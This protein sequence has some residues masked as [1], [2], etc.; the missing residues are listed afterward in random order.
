M[1]K[2]DWS[3]EDYSRS[4][5]K[6]ELRDARGMF[7][8]SLLVLPPLYLGFWFMD[9]LWIPDRKW[10][11]L[12]I[13]CVM[14]CIAFILSQISARSTK[15]K[16]HYWLG[17]IYS[18]FAGN[19]I[20]LMIAI[21]DG[22]TSPYYAGLNLV[23]LGAIWFIPANVKYLAIAIAAICLP[24]TLLPLFV[25]TDSY[26]QFALNN[27]FI[28]GTVI[29]ALF[30]RYTHKRTRESEI[31]ARLTLKQEV[32]NR[33][34]I[35]RE[36]TEEALKLERLS[37]QFS[38]QIVDAIK[39]GEIKLDGEMKRARIAAIFIDIVGSTDR[40][41]NLDRDVF[42]VVLKR[43]MEEVYGV[44]LKYDLTIDKFLGDGVLAFSNEPVKRS[45]FIERTCFA[46]AEIKSRLANSSE[47]FEK[48][49]E[50]KFEIRAG[51]S[52]GHA[53]V[54][55]HGSEKYY[56]SYTAIGRPMA[57]AARLCALAEPGTIVIDA[58]IN[59]VISAEGFQ[60][61]F[62]AKKTLRGF[63]GEVANTYLLDL[64]PAQDFIDTGE[65]ACVACGSNQL[66]LEEANGIYFM[67]CRNCGSALKTAA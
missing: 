62:L 66:T 45:D 35:I 12:G 38:P 10:E 22:P 9:I 58:D 37:S 33:E 59:Q 21:G 13:R 18:F 32:R 63:E 24:Y 60:T 36:K 53:N 51:I 48:Y 19:F 56:K 64:A 67:K 2:R 14:V 54:G 5:A 50:K 20:T 39:S 23:G 46:A 1:S 27:A 44:L 65:M 61:S 55:F 25:H 52:V 15:L 26:L 31:R 7:R 34:R 8:S 47:W 30:I 11:F 17:I 4:I 3:P 43:F 16:T 28:I 42:D 29:M 6:A 49:W 57:M 41:V 40:V